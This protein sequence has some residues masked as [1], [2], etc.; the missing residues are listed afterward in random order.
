MVSAFLSTA[1]TTPLGMLVSYQVVGAIDRN[2]LGALLSAS[3]GTLVYMLGATHLLPRT[4]QERRKCSLVAL[5]GGVM[6]AV[7]ILAHK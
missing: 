3:A 4:E 2:N 1:S 7:I 5:A 6:V